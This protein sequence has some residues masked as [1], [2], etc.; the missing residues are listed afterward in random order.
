MHGGHRSP[1]GAGDWFAFL[2]TR[3][4]RLSTDL[5][6]RERYAHRAVV[7]ETVAA[8]PGMVGLSSLICAA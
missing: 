8:V 6:F 3:A 5:V 1:R 7:L 4:L 2:L